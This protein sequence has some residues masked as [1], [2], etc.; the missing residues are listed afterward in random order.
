MPPTENSFFYPLC[1]SIAL[2]RPYRRPYRLYWDYKRGV[3]L[4]FVLFL[5]LYYSHHVGLCFLNITRYFSADSTSLDGRVQSSV[6]I[7]FRMDT[8]PTGACRY[9]SSNGNVPVVSFG[10]S[11]SRIRISKGLG[12]HIPAHILRSLASA[13]ASAYHSIAHLD[14]CTMGVLVSETRVT[15][16][17]DAAILCEPG[18]ESCALI[19][20]DGFSHFHLSDCVNQRVAHCQ[21]VT[22]YLK[23]SYT[24]HLR[25]SL[26]RID[27]AQDI[28]APPRQIRR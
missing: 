7:F 25:S 24:N 28:L 26:T 17:I 21:R 19:G 8:C 3:R 11:R 6:Q 16:P 23:R 18:R 12:D 2:E 5:F 27:K 1:P 9:M 14:H 4:L 10:T 13:C 22:H 15:T 20:R